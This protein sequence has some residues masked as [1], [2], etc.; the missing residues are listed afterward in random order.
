MKNFST[1]LRM[2]G[3]FLIALMFTNAAMA[4][5]PDFS[6]TW[7][8]NREKSKLGAE[9]SMAPQSMVLVQDAATLT[10]ERHSEFQGQEFVIKDKFTLDGKECLNEGWQ[11]TKKKSTATW[12]DDKKVL[13]IKSAIPM[14]GA[15][16]ISITEKYALTE[17]ALSVVSTSSS[18]WG[19]NSETYVFDK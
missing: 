2:A 15:G 8:L 6:G 16:E 12:S 7:K 4:Q 11:G 13:T 3:L 1:L 14:E 10:V 5:T 17:G 9:F 19:T 18:D